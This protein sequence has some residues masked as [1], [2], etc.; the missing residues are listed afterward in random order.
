M[1]ATCPSC[2]FLLA[3]KQIPYEKEI[4]KIVNNNKLTQKE[5]S[6]AR[7]KLLNDLHIFRECCRIRVMSYTPLEKILVPN[8]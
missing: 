1:H 6:E 8:T 3:D 4:D 7:M 2:N 5:K